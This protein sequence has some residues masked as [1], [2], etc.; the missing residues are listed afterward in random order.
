MSKVNTFL[1]NGEK[2][3]MNTE[4]KITLSDLIHYFS[5]DKLLFVLEYNKLIYSKNDWKNII[6]INNDEIE[7]ITI[8]G[9][10]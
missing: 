2:Y 5:Y 10:G 6:I 9:G 8:V 3:H 7:L 1:L 4:H